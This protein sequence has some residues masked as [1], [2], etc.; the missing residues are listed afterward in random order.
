MGLKTTL[1]GH[2]SF[3]LCLIFILSP[4]ELK[5]WSEGYISSP[6]VLPSQSI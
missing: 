5:A 6:D 4:T 3:S 1:H 2:L